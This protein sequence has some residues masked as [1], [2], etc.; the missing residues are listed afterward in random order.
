MAIQSI[1]AL[2]NAT[3]G[4]FTIVFLLK[5]DG[6]P[7]SDLVLFSLISFGV[8][9]PVCV[10]LVLVRPRRCDVLMVTGL[11][12]LSSSYV[13][14]L[15]VRGWLLLAYVGVAWGLYI[16]LFFVPFNTLIVGTTHAGDRA[17][18]IGGFVF[19][20]TTVAILAPT[21]GG[22]IIAGVGYGV[23]FLFAAIV[24][25]ANALV[26]L[27]FRIGR[28]PLRVAFAFQR[29]GR[30]TIAAIFAQGGFEGLSFGVVPLLVYA[31]TQDELGIGGVFSLFALAG[32]AI[33][34]LLGMLSD[35]MRDRRPFL[36]VGIFATGAA[37]VLV[38]VATSLPA[39][40]LGNSIVS[41]VS[42]IVPL[43]L[44]TLAVERMPE[45]PAHAVVTREVLLNGG[46]TVSLTVVLVLLT[47][48]VSS[49]HTFAI[50]GVCMVFVGLAQP[51]KSLGSEGP[52]DSV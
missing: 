50:A 6:F 24:L 20:Y 8:A 46:R 28:D 27:S 36:L 43:F 39:L 44:M 10:A 4:V 23:V 18:R 35:R 49:F 25:V 21:L 22:T 41:L 19:G 52:R 38:V 45:H 16:P 26:I 48:G 17:G 12:I 2:A 42:P 13:A 14:Y 31:F 1:L 29:L 3:A 15:V 34:L 30:R 33:V 51:W 32:G 37:S 5:I 7:V 40:A 47:L 9:V 11:L